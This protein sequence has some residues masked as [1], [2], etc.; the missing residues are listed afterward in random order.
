MCIRDSGKTVLYDCR[1]GEAFDQ[2]VTVG[3][4]YYL[5]LHHLVDD[6]IHARSKMCIRD[7]RRTT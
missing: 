6:K 3:Y 4:Q 7:R 1:T 5:K 2:R